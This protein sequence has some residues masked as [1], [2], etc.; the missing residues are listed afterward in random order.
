MSKIKLAQS[1]LVVNCIKHS[2]GISDMSYLLLIIIACGHCRIAVTLTPS[3]YKMNPI[4]F[5]GHNKYFQ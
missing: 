4:I 5:I 2:M 1:I 3:S